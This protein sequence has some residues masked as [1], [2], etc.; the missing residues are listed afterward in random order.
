MSNDKVLKKME[1]KRRLI[2]EEMV[3]VSRPHNRERGFEKNQYSQDRLKAQDRGKLY[4][5]HCELE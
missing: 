4:N 3:E 2:L 1:T 5:I